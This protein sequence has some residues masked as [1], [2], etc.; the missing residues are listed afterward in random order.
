MKLKYVPFA[1]KPSSM[2][3]PL[4]SLSTPAAIS[5]QASFGISPLASSNTPVDRVPF[6]YIDGA[7][8]LN[9]SSVSFIGFES[10]L[11]ALVP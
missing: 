9:G 8:P 5:S 10:F 4:A 11:G 2:L 3:T 7:A 6:L 1:F